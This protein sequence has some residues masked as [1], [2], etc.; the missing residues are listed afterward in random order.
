VGPNPA[1]PHTQLNPIGPRIFVCPDAGSIS[2]SASP[3][4]VVA[5]ASRRSPTNA[6]SPDDEVPGGYEATATNAPLCLDT[7]KS[8]EPPPA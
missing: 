4:L 6:M 5:E 7:V 3:E 8:V 1:R 2:T